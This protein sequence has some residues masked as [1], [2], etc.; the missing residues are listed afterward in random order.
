MGD[1]QKDC[2]L[3][4]YTKNILDEVLV[5]DELTGALKKWCKLLWKKTT[6]NGF[7]AEL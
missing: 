6:F 4:H 1:L 7:L 3:K 2:K 5:A